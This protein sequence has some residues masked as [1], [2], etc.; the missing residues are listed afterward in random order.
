MP[1]GAWP[2]R[3]GDGGM[4]R[5]RRGE[6][7]GS[8]APV[9]GNYRHYYGMR[10][11]RAA[12]QSRRPGDDV[13]TPRAD[14]MDA[15]VAALLAWYD[16][17]R[18]RHGVA[19][20]DVGP[21]ERVLDIGCNAAKPLLELCQAMRPPP[22]YVLGVDVDAALIEQAQHALRRAWSLRQPSTAADTP[23]ARYFPRA[24]PAFLGDLPLPPPSTPAFPRHVHFAVGDWMSLPVDG[25]YD[26]VLAWSVNK[27][28]HLHHGDD[29]LV[30]WCARLAD[31]LSPGGLLVLELQPW[32]SYE[33]ARLLSP[34]LRAAHARLR[35]Q[36][37]DLPYLLDV[38][39]LLFLEELGLGTGHGTWHAAYPRFSAAAAHFSEIRRPARGA[40]R[41]RGPAYMALGATCPTKLGAEPRPCA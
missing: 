41:P 7:Q 33:Q 13:V 19:T 1:L 18:R 32:A 39:G 15:R 25:P 34:E 2:Q 27:W 26:L 14:G 9:Y 37:D 23:A 5:G 20:A 28:I 6:T 16:V 36:P 12:A 35:L 40:A 11:S 30:A 17:R 4:Q 3:L 8:P 31:A 29:G 24:L 21:V 10:S 38:Y 22:A